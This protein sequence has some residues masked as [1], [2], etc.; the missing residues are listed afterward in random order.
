ML[1]IGLLVLSELFYNPKTGNGRPGV[2]VLGD[3]LHRGL[4]MCRS[5]RNSSGPECVVDLRCW[6][7][8]W[9]NMPYSTV[10]PRRMDV[11]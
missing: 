10:E 9:C 6:C 4:G 1:W 8:R 5:C 2:F 7:I 3:L 11:S